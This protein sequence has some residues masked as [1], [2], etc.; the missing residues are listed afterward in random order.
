MADRGYAVFQPNFRG[1]T[2]YGK[3][4]MDAGLRR[5]G[6]EMQ[7]DL[8]DGVA[9]LVRLG[10]ADAKRVVIVGASY[11]GYAALMGVCKTP[12]LYRGAFAF[13]P[14]TD[15]VELTA[16]AGQFTR[17]EAIRKQ[18]GETSDDKERLLATSPRFLADRIE[19]PVV[20]VHGTHDRQAQY[21]HS[22]WMAEELKAKGK[23]YKFV[24][25]DRGDHQLSHLPYRKQV[26]EL[27]ETFLAQTAGGAS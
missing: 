5:W 13:A 18:I 4:F 2:G 23:T 21:D 7:D 19:K 3:P 16:E 6:L 24:T 10:I 11:G 12:Q 8:S 17:R 20:L 25:L 15:L 1:S 14:V 22:V 27:L 9:E 26:F